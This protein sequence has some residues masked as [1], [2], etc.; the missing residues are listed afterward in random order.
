MLLWLGEGRRKG[1][2]G[3]G[4]WVMRDNYICLIWGWSGWE[5]CS[6]RR[7]CCS[8]QKVPENLT[9]WLQQWG[10]LHLEMMKAQPWGV[11]LGTVLIRL[12]WLQRLLQ[13]TLRTEEFSARVSETLRLEASP[14]AVWSL[15]LAIWLASLSLETGSH[16]PP[17]IRRKPPQGL[18][19]VSSVEM[20]RPQSTSQL[21]SGHLLR[22]SSQGRPS[23]CIANRLREGKGLLQKEF[24]YQTA[25]WSDAFWDP[26]P[27]DWMWT[28]WFF[29]KWV[30]CSH[31]GAHSVCEEKFTCS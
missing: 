24:L 23:S 10:W 28:F 29:R 22:V 15:K 4:G 11:P 2:P 5:L 13:A 16:S 17:I 20:P 25:L 6:L 9:V 21:L 30:V 31:S 14:W 27:P 1:I 26:D 3:R 19:T 12:F 18:H 8:R 7:G